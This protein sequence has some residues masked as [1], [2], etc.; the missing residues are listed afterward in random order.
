MKV[1]INEV[2]FLIDLLDKYKQELY[3]Y[4]RDDQYPMSNILSFING[5]TVVVD[6]CSNCIM[7][8]IMTKG[9]NPISNF[10]TILF[11]NCDEMNKAFEE[12][13]VNNI[14]NLVDKYNKWE[15]VGIKYAICLV[16]FYTNN[17]VFGNCSIIDCTYLDI[18]NKDDPDSYNW[19]ERGW[20]YKYLN[21]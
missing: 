15:A 6:Y 2:N 21:N 13:V 18:P 17:I 1:T 5:Y 7:D 8:I 19:E 11:N 16:K 10:K 3:I 20:N 4:M 14:F 9:Y 12:K